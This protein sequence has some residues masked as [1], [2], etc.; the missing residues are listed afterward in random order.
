MRLFAALLSALFLLPPAPVLADSQAEQAQGLLR[1][2]PRDSITERAITVRGQK[3]T[4]VATAGTLDLFG[5]DGNRNAKIFYTAYTLKDAAADKRPLT[6]A[7]NGGPGAA[8]VY[9]HLGV[10]GPKIASFANRDGA[11]AQ[12]TDNPDTWLPFT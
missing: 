1:L 2:L 6:F 4:Y 7:F 8:S 9:L 3:L 12:L 5:Q 10:A 11:N